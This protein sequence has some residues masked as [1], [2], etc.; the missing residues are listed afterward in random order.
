MHS[1]EPVL[2]SHSTLAEV[3]I[4]D[5]RSRSERP[6]LSCELASARAEFFNRIGQL[7][8]LATVRFAGS[9]ISLQAR[10]S[11]CAG[12]LREA[13]RVCWRGRR[14]CHMSRKSPSVVSNLLGFDESGSALRGP[15]LLRARRCNANGIA[16]AKTLIRATTMTS[17]RAC[18]QECNLTAATSARPLWR[19]CRARSSN[20]R[21]EHGRNAP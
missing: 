21:Q 6:F 11:R 4:V 5:P 12:S 15:R 3:A 2:R 8:A 19:R 10:Y 1:A 14:A 7:R 16:I 13:A 20:A 18:A 17:M 9:Q